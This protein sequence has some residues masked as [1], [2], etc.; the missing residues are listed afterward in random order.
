MYSN[1]IRARIQKSEDIFIYI[2]NGC[3]VILHRSGLGAHIPNKLIKKHCI[4]NKIQITV[5]KILLVFRSTVIC[6]LLEIL[7]IN[8]YLIYGG[9][10]VRY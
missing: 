9:N 1:L 6:V 4:E 7:L 10:Y 5:P 3:S 2:I 8:K